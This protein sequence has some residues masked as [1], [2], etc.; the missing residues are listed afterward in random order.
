MENLPLKKADAEL[1][2]SVLIDWLKKKNIQ[3]HKLVGMSFDVG[4]QHLQ[5]RNLKFRHD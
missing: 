2:C 5:E 4:P 1:I 3:C